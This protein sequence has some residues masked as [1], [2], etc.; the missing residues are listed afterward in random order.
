MI[1]NLTSVSIDM[2][3]RKLLF[4]MPPGLQLRKAETKTEATKKSDFADEWS[5]QRNAYYIYAMLNVIIVI[6]MTTVPP[7]GRDQCLFPCVVDL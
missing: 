7:L 4:G 6:R 3:F 2:R 5:P 1:S